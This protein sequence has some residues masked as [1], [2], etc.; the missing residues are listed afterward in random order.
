MHDWNVIVTV[1]PG[2]GHEE[3]LLRGLRALGQFHRCGFKD[4]Y[5][6]RIDQVD[7]FLEA[8]LR[9]QSDG[10]A[11]VRPL[12][13][14]IPVETVFHFTQDTLA[15]QFGRAAG[16]LLAR[17]GN[18]SFYVRVERR[19]LAGEIDTPRIERD[20]ADQ[21]FSLAELQGLQLRVSFADPDYIIVA[22]TIGEACGVA[23][24][25]R[26]LRNRYPFVQTR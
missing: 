26:E 3:R 8:L 18:G 7:A 2:R 16:S 6:G 15:E 1:L 23:L 13:R 24:I 4:L 21:L 19:G 9:A 12:G 25:P 20:V 10:A 22:E 14:V 11:W 17:M 5:V